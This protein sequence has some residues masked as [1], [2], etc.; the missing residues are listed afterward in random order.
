MSR[1]KKEIVN[2]NCLEEGHVYKVNKP[3]TEPFS[4]IELPFD[5]TYASEKNELLSFFKMKVLSKKG[6]LVCHFK[7][8]FQFVKLS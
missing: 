6:V 7:T 3:Q 5:F 2:Y 1:K 8:S 4:I